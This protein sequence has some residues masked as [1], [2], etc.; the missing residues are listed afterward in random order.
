MMQ[1]LSVVV[2]LRLVFIDLTA[3]SNTSVQWSKGFIFFFSVRTGIYQMP[4][5]A[6][7][8]FLKGSFSHQYL[9]IILIYS[10][11]SSSCGGVRAERYIANKSWVLY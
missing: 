1:L 4:S 2:L 9:H 5:F 7:N 6:Q 3:Q 11:N 8:H 10:D